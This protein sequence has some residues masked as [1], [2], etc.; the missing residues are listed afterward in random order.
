MHLRKKVYLSVLIL[1]MMK[2]KTNLKFYL[3]FSE[4]NLRKLDRTVNNTSNIFNSEMKQ[5]V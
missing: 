4:E 3:R 1:Y 2:L 5:K